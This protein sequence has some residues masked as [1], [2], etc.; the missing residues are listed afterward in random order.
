[1]AATGA[2]PG[3][4][5]RLRSFAA[6]YSTELQLL[7]A[8]AV[9]YAIFAALYP[10][11]FV[12]ENNTVNM[13]RAGGILLVVAIAQMSA[14]VVGG[15]D[16]SVGANMGFVATL[17]AYFMVKLG[18]S[19][20]WGVVLGLAIGAGVGLING[21][22]ISAVRINPLITTLGMATFLLGL[23]FIPN[24]AQPIFGLPP[25]Y[26]Q[27]FGAGDWGPIPAPV[28]I[29]AIVVVLM[30]L[31]L[32]RSRAGVYIY[33][34]GGSRDT[35]RISGVPIIRYE[36]LA[37]TLCGLLAGL[38]GLMLGA[39]ISIVNAD[40]GASSGY[41]LESIATAVIGG[42]LIGGGVGRLSGVVLGVALLTVLE[43]GLD[44]AKVHDFVQ[45]MVKGVVLVSA[46]LIAQLRAGQLR[47]I[48]RVLRPGRPRTVATLESIAAGRRQAG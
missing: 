44:I 12:T 30:W 27:Y 17:A 13:A 21:F 46:V 29:G 45:Q 23:G 43:T 15:F 37:Y 11:V 35:C 7:V 3:A 48:A 6:T 40:I 25:D 38:A 19:I 26:V 2:R 39:R 34:I 18:Y 41:D 28:C 4:G 24:G 5:R 10:S 47:D 32:A 16:L 22:L 20:G 8:L 9:L 31:V 42:A 36:I 1:V 33:G 14:L